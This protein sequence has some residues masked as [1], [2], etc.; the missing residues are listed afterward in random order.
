MRTRATRSVF[1]GYSERIIKR[2]ISLGWNREEQDD[3]SVTLENYGITG[4]ESMRAKA[5][6]DYP[7]QVN[8]AIEM[9]EEIKLKAERRGGGI[10]KGQVRKPGETNKKITF[11]PQRLPLTLKE[12]EITY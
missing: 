7:E 9:A 6:C 1:E 3:S 10:L 11:D 12:M 4:R 2:N 5:L 8:E